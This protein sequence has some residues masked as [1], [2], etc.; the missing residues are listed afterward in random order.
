MKVFLYYNN[1]Y[2]V[3]GSGTVGGRSLPLFQE[4]SVF[5]E[6]S[7]RSVFTTVPWT[8]GEV[9]LYHCSKNC[10]RGR[11]L[12]LFQELSVVGLYHCSW[13]CRRGRFLPLFLELSERSV[14]TTVQRTVGGRS[15]PLFLER[16][17]VGL[18]G[19]G[20]LPLRGNVVIALCNLVRVQELVGFIV[21]F[22]LNNRGAS[23]ISETVDLSFLRLFINQ[24]QTFIS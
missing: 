22:Y 8:V 7:D 4:L 9:G 18:E 23:V 17:E 5:Q 19:P 15:L 3:G 20:T 14:S 13:N 10:R 6:L 16:T 2:E 1:F 21:F 12:P 11:S 24:I